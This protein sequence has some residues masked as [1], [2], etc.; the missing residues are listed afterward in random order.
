M[1]QWLS[2]SPDSRLLGQFGLKQDR[3]W[4]LA[5]WDLQTGGPIGSIPT[6]PYTFPARHFSSTHSMD[7]KKVAVAYGNTDA[8]ITAISAYDLL[9]GTRTRSYR[10]SEGRIVAPIWTHGEY[11]RFVTVKPGSITVWEV[12]FTSMHA[13][14]GIKSLPGPDDINCSEECLFLPTLSR[15]A[16]TFQGA[17]LVWDA[18][19]SKLLLKSPNTDYPTRMT[20][21]SDGRL[22]AYGTTRGKIYLWK[23]SPTGYVLQKVIPNPDGFTG[24]LLSPNGESIIIPDNMTIQLL[25]IADPTP[26]VPSV[27]TQPTEKT[28]F[29][30]EFSPGETLAAVVRLEG[31]TAT[32][33][34]LESGDPRLIIDAGMKIHGLRVTESTVVIVGEGKVVTWNLP[35]ENS[36]LNPRASITDSV[37]TTLFDYSAPPN[38]DPRPVPCTSISPDL[39][40]VAVAWD[41][42]GKYE[43]LNVYDLS[44]GKCVMGTA[45][46]GYM[47]WFTPDACE[48]WCRSLGDSAEG[49][50]IMEDAES[51]LLELES[52]GPTAHPLGGLPWRSPRDYQVTHSGWIADSSRSRLLWLPHRW[53]SNDTY[54]TWRGRFLGLLHRELPE[55]VILEFGE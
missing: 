7:G 47:P 46:K 16:F 45:T 51:D 38:S 20:F 19:D 17:A 30:V 43:G 49:W 27:P 36:A 34:D 29:I 18:Q 37:Q 42:L 5:S 9:S 26:S 23:E 31:N 32:V 40:Q 8:T 3:T 41:T 39:D 50:A 4:E 13:P 15:L 25:R 33:L 10:P 55:A 12:G 53:R 2:F 28:S 6:E 22:F 35:A 44:T 48:I 21:S 52:L 1:A 24:P 54:M 11:I 14:T